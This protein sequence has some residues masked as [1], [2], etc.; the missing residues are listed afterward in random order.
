[1][2]NNFPYFDFVGT[3]NVEDDFPTLKIG[4]V[5]RAEN[6]LVQFDGAGTFDNPYQIKTPQD[7]L[8]LK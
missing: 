8:S 4:G 7:F 1:M 2:G 5:T 3:W 6:P